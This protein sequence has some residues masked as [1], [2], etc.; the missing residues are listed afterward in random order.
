M[1]GGRTPTFFRPHPGNPSRVRRAP[2]TGPPG[3]GTKNPAHGD[4]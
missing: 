1:P 4:A 3:A 2:A